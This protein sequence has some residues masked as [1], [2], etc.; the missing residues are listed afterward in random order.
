MATSLIFRRIYTN[1]QD[2][3]GYHARGKWDESYIGLKMQQSMEP[4]LTDAEWRLE[5]PGVTLLPG[6][7]S[8]SGTPGRQVGT[9]ALLRRGDSE[10]STATIRTVTQREA[11]SAT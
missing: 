9:A 10:P 5:T 8:D 3:V 2:G 4:S 6:A 1:V 11:K 7:R